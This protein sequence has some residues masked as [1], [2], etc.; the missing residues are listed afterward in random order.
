MLHGAGDCDDSP[1]R[2]AA[3]LSHSTH[4]TSSLAGHHFLF[5][6]VLK[7]LGTGWLTF[8]PSVIVDTWLHA[9]QWA[10]SG[11]V[12]IVGEAGVTVAPDVM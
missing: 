7:F 9:L 12:V 8:T 2:V 11:E 1:L 6:I 5:L 3:V 10:A 4:L